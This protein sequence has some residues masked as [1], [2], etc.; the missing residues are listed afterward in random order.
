VKNKICPQCGKEFKT[1]LH[2]HKYCSKSCVIE[3]RKLY[4]RKHERERKRILREN[5][6]FR[7][8]EY[9][10]DNKRFRERYKNDNEFRE[11]C[12]TSAK[13]WRDKNSEKVNKN[14]KLF[15]D[16]QIVELDRILDVKCVICDG[17]HRLTYH[18]IYGKPHTHYRGY[19][20]KHVKDFTRLCFYCHCATHYLA[21]QTNIP[22][23]TLLIKL[24][25]ITNEN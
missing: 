11:Q 17:N 3:Q 2:Q 14:M 21:N 25:R 7:T 19:I 23:E 1:G 6:E 24:I 13:K 20:L 18:E 16:K 12:K 15:R 4:Q 22:I 5:P 9:K 8:M 10:R